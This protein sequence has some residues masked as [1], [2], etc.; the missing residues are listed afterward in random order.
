[1]GGRVRDLTGQKFGELTVLQ[2]TGERQRGG[3]AVWLCRCSC[4]KICKASGNALTDGRKKSCGHTKMR[5]KKKKRF[6]RLVAIRPIRRRIES[7]PN[8]FAWI[9]KC[10]CGSVM[11]AASPNL[12]NGV[13]K[14]CGC[15]LR[16]GGKGHVVCPSCGERFLINIDGNPTPQF[17]EKCAPKYEGRNWKV[18]PVCRKLFPSPASEKT[19]TCSKECSAEWKRKTHDGVSNKWN[20]D[21]KDKKRKQGQTDN[22]KLGTP[23]AMASPIAG[24]FETNQEAK[25]WTLID[26][27]GNEILVRNLL[28]W[29]RENTEQFGKTEGDKS[30]KQIA[31]GFRAIAL[32][33][34]GKRKHPSMTYFGWTLKDAPKEREE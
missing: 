33:M 27:L 15:L 7:Q 12:I 22:L 3:G 25:I 2:D 29:S 1:M 30:A 23:A 34:R 32:T 16:G 5:K 8:S 26:P 4:G 9:C 14:S 31:D 24:R 20:E 13:K 17:C 21:S 28:M 6:G 18:C 11:I 10:D 19:V